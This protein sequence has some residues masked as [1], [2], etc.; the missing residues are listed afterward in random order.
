MSAARI[1]ELL[2][3]IATQ[4]DNIVDLSHLT[5]CDRFTNAAVAP[6]LFKDIYV[7]SRSLPGLWERFASNTEFA[8]QCRSLVIHGPQ[9]GTDR[10]IEQPEVFHGYDMDSMPSHQVLSQSAASILREVCQYGRLQRFSWNTYHSRD[11]GYGSFPLETGFWTALLRTG[12]YLHELDL[13][14]FPADRE[15]FALLT[16]DGDFPNLKIFRLNLRDNH[17]SPHFQTFLSRLK[18]IQHLDLRIEVDPRSLPSGSITFAADHPHLRSLSMTLSPCGLPPDLDFIARHQTIEILK[19]EIAQLFYCDDSCLP[20]LRA[21]SVEQ[22][23]VLYCSAFVSP[24]AKRSVKHLALVGMPLFTYPNQTDSMVRNI[25]SA[26]ASSLTCLEMDFLEID[27]F[28]YWI[29]DI[30]KL[31]HL[32]PNLLE[33][34]MIARSPM[35]IP[36]APSFDGKDLTDLLAVLDHGSHLQALRFFDLFKS[37]SVLP[38]PLLANLGSVPSSLRYIKWDVHPDPETYRLETLDGRT[39]AVAMTRAPVVKDKVD[40]TSDSVLDHSR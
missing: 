4:L 20:N 2:R 31:L 6:L 8:Q 34:G 30:S 35:P 14:I 23:T 22:S 9:L 32:V 39:T 10:L 21:L 16:R 18:Q 28:R 7:A 13:A 19:L 5:Q 3:E 29:R 38:E 15:G 1:P 36:V 40:W 11:Y 17:L 25:V 27:D 24:S 37:G 12:D 33:F 26:M